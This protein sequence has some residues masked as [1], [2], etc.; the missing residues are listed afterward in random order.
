MEARLWDEF[1]S[2]H[3]RW[4]LISLSNTDV[5]RLD[6]SLFWKFSLS[7]RDIIKEEDQYTPVTLLEYLKHLHLV[8]WDNLVKDT[9]ILAGRRTYSMVR[10]HSVARMRRVAVQI[11]QIIYLFLLYWVQSR[12]LHLSSHYVPVSGLL[13]VHRHF[14]E[15]YLVW[16]TIQMPLNFFIV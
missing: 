2:L 6:A 15:L 1:H 10:A 3:N 13:F 11:Q 16:W 5:H 14:T 9:K 8:E 7:L 12:V 4:Q